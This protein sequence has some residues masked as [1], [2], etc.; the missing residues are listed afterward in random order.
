[1]ATTVRRTDLLRA[2]IAPFLGFFNG[3]YAQLEKD[4]ETANF[5][6]GNP[7]KKAMPAYIEALRGVLEP[8]DKDSE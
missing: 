6:V 8:R 3:P 7:Q 2:S 1:M 5:A 4:A